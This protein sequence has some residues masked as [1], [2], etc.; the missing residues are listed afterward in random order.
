MDPWN[1]ILASDYVHSADPVFFTGGNTTQTL[2][3]FIYSFENFLSQKI[4][5]Y[6][7]LT[8]DFL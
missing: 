6:L 5:K 2:V 1:M 3:F 7:N 8:F 4:L